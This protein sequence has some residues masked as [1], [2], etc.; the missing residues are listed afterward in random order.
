MMAAFWLQGGLFGWSPGP[1]HAVNIVLHGL[2]AWALLLTARALGAS[3]AGAWFGGLLFLVF[4]PA[5]ESVGSVVGRCDV[6]ALLLVLLRWR[7]QLL[8]AGG[9]GGDGP[10]PGATRAAFSV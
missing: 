10:A 4:P 8:W 6:L 9:T 1:F 2:A 7:S 5:Q 3:G